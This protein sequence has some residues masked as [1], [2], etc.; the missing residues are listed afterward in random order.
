MK[1]T[2]IPKTQEELIN[3][4]RTPLDKWLS[5]KNS[6]EMKLYIKETIPEMIYNDEF[7][8]SLVRLE[9][10]KLIQYK[11]NLLDSAKKIDLNPLLKSET[12]SDN[13]DTMESSIGKN[14]QYSA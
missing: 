6:E 2:V 10:Y 1:K 4:F 11:K 8:E 3:S 12:K 5:I 7:L 14:I 13:L 9:F